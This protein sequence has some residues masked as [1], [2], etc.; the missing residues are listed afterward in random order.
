MIHDGKISKLPFDLAEA[1]AHLRASDAKLG[2]LIERAGRR[3]IAA[4]H[5][6]QLADFMGPVAVAVGQLHEH[7][8]IVEAASSAA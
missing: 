4:L 3:A 2:M 1:L 7:G 8:M 5:H 6:P